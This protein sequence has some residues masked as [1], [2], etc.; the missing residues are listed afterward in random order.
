M[1]AWLLLSVR[2][3]TLPATLVLYLLVLLP[4]PRDLILHPFSM[5]SFFFV[6]PSLF[7][8]PYLEIL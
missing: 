3:P 4:P 6:I 8:G 5:P 2:M 7:I 1:V